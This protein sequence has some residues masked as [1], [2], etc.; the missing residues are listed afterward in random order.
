MNSKAFHLI[1]TTAGLVISLL[2]GGVAFSQEFTPDTAI[3]AQ[4]RKMA[5]I[6]NETG[7]SFLEE[8]KNMASGNKGEL[9]RQAIWFS[10]K[11]HGEFEAWMGVILA[12]QVGIT[13]SEDILRA[14]TPF[15]W[16]R[17]EDVKRVLLEFVYGA[18]EPRATNDRK[19]TELDFRHFVPMLEANKTN[20]PEVLVYYMFSFSPSKALKVLSEIY[21]ED[22]KEREKISDADRAIGEYLQ[23][24]HDVPLKERTAAKLRDTQAGQQAQKALDFLSQRSEWPVKRYVETMKRYPELRF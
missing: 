20:P 16:T 22:P 1:L 5:S 14:I 11:T 6:T 7:Y 18:A 2:C 12:G 15:L 9:T 24:A 21:I 17:D 13:N 10:A 3:Q 19:T 8:F 4:I 23:F